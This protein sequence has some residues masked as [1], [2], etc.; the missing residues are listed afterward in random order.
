MARSNERRKI[1]H[2]PSTHEIFLCLSWI[3]AYSKILADHG[4][5]KSYSDFLDWLIQKRF[6]NDR[7][8]KVIIKNIAKEYKSDSAKVTKWMREIYEE[9]FD[10]NYDRPELFQKEGVKVCLYFS[11]YD[12]GCTFYTSLPAVPREFETVRFPFVKGKV[13]IDFFW[14]K[15]V[16]HEIIE[17]VTSISIWLSGGFLNK[18]RQ[19]A[20]DKAIFHG[21]IHFTDVYD[22]H[23]FELDDEIRKIYR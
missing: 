16:E 22:R 3:P 5:R 4:P 6:Y 2:N 14:V 15:N 23:D 10:L 21:L 20:L 7:T 18:Y 17:D 11:H 1:L 19:F 12:N 9:I 13:G 8:G